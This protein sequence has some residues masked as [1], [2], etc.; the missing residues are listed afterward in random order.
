MKRIPVRRA[1][2]E[3]GKRQYQAN[4]DGELWERMTRHKEETG[5]SY[6]EQISR[7]AEMYLNARG[8]SDDAPANPN[9]LRLE[10]APDA[11]A[12]LEKLAPLMYHTDALTQI[13]WKANTVEHWYDKL[14]D[15]QKAKLAPTFQQL[16]EVFQ[17]F[18]EA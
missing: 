4:F 10:L 3:K 17:R 2:G 7:G 13:G 18:S 8:A 14:S 9:A 5:V 16:A 1:I 6:M 12:R 15:A 11:M